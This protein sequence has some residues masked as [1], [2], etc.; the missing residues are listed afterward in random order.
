MGLFFERIELAR[1]N[2]SGL[3][4]VN[5]AQVGGAIQSKEDSELRIRYGRVDSIRSKN[6]PYSRRGMS[7]VRLL[8]RYEQCVKNLSILI[9]LWHRGVHMSTKPSGRSCILLAPILFL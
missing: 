7:A 1:P 5:S 4:R 9:R 8:L 3:D 2:G 6:R